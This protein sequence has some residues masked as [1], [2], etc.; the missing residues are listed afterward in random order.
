MLRQVMVAT[1]NTDSVSLDRRCEP[2][3]CAVDSVCLCVCLCVPACFRCVLCI[4]VFNVCA[5]VCVCVC[6]CVCVIVSCVV[7]VLRRVKF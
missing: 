3:R 4:Q 1:R 2:C 6:A 7:C 5:C